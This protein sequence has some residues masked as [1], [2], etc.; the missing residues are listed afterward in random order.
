MNRTIRWM[1]TELS[2]RPQFQLHLQLAID[3]VMLC[4]DGL[5]LL[6]RLG[7]L[8]YSFVGVVTTWRDL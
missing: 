7:I 5:D 3:L 6:Y 8:L 2:L 4:V 1:V